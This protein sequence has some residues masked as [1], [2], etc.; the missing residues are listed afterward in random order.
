MIKNFHMLSPV[1][2]KT[3]KKDLGFGVGKSIKS[4]KI[5]RGSD[6]SPDELL[7][8]ATS[9]EEFR[10][11]K[12]GGKTFV[13]DVDT[14][15]SWK[16]DA[17]KDHSYIIMNIKYKPVVNFVYG[18][19]YDVDSETERGVYDMDD[20]LHLSL[21]NSVDDSVLSAMLKHFKINPD[22]VHMPN[23]R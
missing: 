8:M 19:W 13:Y 16:V 2:K 3:V 21:W 11:R 7:M 18:R 14:G 10:N 23:K 22:F 1:E 5:I 4:G 15:K 6:I 12:G 17:A 20:G 9:D